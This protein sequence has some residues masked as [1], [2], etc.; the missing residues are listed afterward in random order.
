MHV[1]LL[2]A[3]HQVRREASNLV[4]QPLGRNGGNLLSNL[5][6]DLEIQGQLAVI[7]FHD[8]PRCFLHGFCSNAAHCCGKLRNSTAR[9]ALPQV[10]DV[11]SADTVQRD[12]LLFP[13]LLVQQHERCGN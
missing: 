12:C 10:P 7:L 2:N 11:R 5:L 9:L 8:H 6:V 1:S 13:T 4:S 3:L